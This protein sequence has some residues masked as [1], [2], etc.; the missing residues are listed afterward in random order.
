MIADIKKIYITHCSAKKNSIFKNTRAKVTPD[1]LYT[2]TPTQR[3]MIAKI[4]EST[5][6]Y[7]LTGTEYGFQIFSMNGIAPT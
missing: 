5:G 6:Q 2:A 3:F 7:F 1:K 4:R